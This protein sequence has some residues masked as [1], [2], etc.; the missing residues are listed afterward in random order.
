MTA[1]EGARVAALTK[2]NSTVDAV[3]VRAMAIPAIVQ[4]M[5]RDAAALLPG[6]SRRAPDE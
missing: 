3:A 6:G 1:E 2:L 5:G 4:L